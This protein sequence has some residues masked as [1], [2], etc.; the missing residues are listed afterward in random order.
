[1]IRTVLL[2]LLAWALAD[3]VVALGWAAWFNYIDPLERDARSADEKLTLRR[4]IAAWFSR[5][6]RPSHRRDRR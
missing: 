4:R 5:Y 6:I 1:M 2:I 3:A